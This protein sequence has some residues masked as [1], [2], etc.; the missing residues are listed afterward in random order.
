MARAC[1]RERATQET[2]EFGLFGSKV[3]LLQLPEQFVSPAPQVVTHTPAEHAWPPG[4]TLPQ[5]P[6]LLLSV[7]TLISQPF[8]AIASQLRK[9]ALQAPRPQAP[10]VHVDAALAKEQRTPQPPQLFTSVERTL[11]SQPLLAVPS[12]SPKPVVH[13]PTRQLEPEHA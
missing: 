10:V 5:A 9:P 11:V 3:T 2:M 4:H 7:L 13:E 12:Q 1:S 6:Q 8:V